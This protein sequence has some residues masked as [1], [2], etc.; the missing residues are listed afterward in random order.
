MSLPSFERGPHSPPLPANKS[1]IAIARSADGLMTEV[2]LHGNYRVSAEDRA[3]LGPHR[4]RHQVW[5]VAVHRVSRGSFLGRPGADSVVFAEEEPSSG[6][7][8]G[9]FTVNLAAVLRLPRAAAGAYDVTA[10]LGPLRSVPIGV[11]LRSG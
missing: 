2:L 5:I 10:V 6:A 7:V 9:A 1:G 3:H 4:V 11:L 8:E